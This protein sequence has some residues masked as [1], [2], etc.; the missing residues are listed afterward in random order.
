MIHQSEVRQKKGA[1]K[2]NLGTPI[3]GIRVNLIDVETLAT[4]A[5]NALTLMLND[6]MLEELYGNKI[7]ILLDAGFSIEF[8]IPKLDLTM[9]GFNGNNKG[10]AKEI[11][12]KEFHKL[13]SDPAV[14][15]MMQAKLDTSNDF[16]SWFLFNLQTCLHAAVCKKMNSA[17]EF[18]VHVAALS[19]DEKEVICYIAGAI[20]SKLEK[21]FHK[22]IKI[23]TLENK[24]T[25]DEDITMLGELKAEDYTEDFNND[26]I[27][28]LNR[29]GLVR[30]KMQYCEVLF[31]AENT[32]REHSNVTSTN[33]NAK[34]ILQLCQENPEVQNK[35]INLM[36][37]SCSNENAL[38]LLK[39]VLSLYIKI[40]CH[41]HAKQTIEKYRTQIKA[42]FKKKGIRKELKD[43]KDEEEKDK[44]KKT[45][46]DKN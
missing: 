34:H 31:L 22:M 5:K 42:S 30:P 8:L 3:G 7:R 25:F 2:E 37:Q 38:V 9:K 23:C 21:K 29:G 11:M 26:L 14:I 44:K 35:F 33:I 41:S 16:I 4:V 24:A 6:A 12:W 28:I 39:M 13:A 32:F 15:S 10:A 43:K 46:V 1:K 40:R 45:K 36:P 19:A 27:A 17:A 20:I 18:H